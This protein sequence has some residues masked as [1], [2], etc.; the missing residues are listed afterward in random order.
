LEKGKK[1]KKKIDESAILCA[2]TRARARARAHASWCI[3]FLVSEHGRF[4]T[5]DLS[6]MAFLTMRFVRILRASGTKELSQEV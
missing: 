3:R 6:R 1:R 4:N 2:S 5:S